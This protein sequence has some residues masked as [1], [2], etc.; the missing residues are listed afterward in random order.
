MVSRPLP[1]FSESLRAPKWT[2]IAQ[3]CLKLADIHVKITFRWRT[4]DRLGTSVFLPST[5]SPQPFTHLLRQL[6]SRK[7][8][9]PYSPAFWSMPL[10]TKPPLFVMG[11][12]DSYIVA[13]SKISGD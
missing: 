3:K 5:V 6:N 1:G 9:V 13:C 2:Q 4:G 8:M 7:K 11:Q 10:Y 12:V